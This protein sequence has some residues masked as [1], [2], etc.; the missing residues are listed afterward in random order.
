MRLVAISI[1]IFMTGSGYAQGDGTLTFKVRKVE[2][3]YL[4]SNN[5]LADSDDPTDHI[6]VLDL[7]SY[8]PARLQNRYVAGRYSRIV[9]C[10][11]ILTNAKGEVTRLAMNQ[12]P[13]LDLLVKF[14]CLE[15]GSTV[16]I[17]QLQVIDSKEILHWVPG[18]T[19]SAVA[20]GSLQRVQRIMK[21]IT[22]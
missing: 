18:L 7:V 11:I 12:P 8:I 14:V 2:Y 5:A 6:S 17:D 1:L 3:T 22:G 9:S 15:P 21:K 20:A 16:E 10:R 19:F 4:A 13:I